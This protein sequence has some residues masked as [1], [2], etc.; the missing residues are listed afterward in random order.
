MVQEKCDG[1]GTSSNALKRE[2]V[3]AVCGS[4]ICNY[5]SAAAFSKKMHK[6]VR[7]CKTCV[8]NLE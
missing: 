2:G 8:S 4:L 7:C 5:C 6:A 1:C 3:C